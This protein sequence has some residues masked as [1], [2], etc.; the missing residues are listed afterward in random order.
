MC[1]AQ[2][3]AALLEE[4]ECKQEL[5]WGAFQLGWAQAFSFTCAPDSQFCS[6][7]SHPAL[8]VRVGNPLYHVAVRACQALFNQQHYSSRFPSRPCPALTSTA[9]PLSTFTPHLSSLGVLYVVTHLNDVAHF[10]LGFR[11]NSECRGHIPSSVPGQP[12][13]APACAQ[14]PSL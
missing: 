1:G 8:A 5:G 12:Q 13:P 6:P 7:P 10:L 3:S 14:P 9:D 2:L 11:E 4:V